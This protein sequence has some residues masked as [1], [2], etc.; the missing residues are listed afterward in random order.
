MSSYVE[1]RRIAQLHMDN[2][3]IENADPGSINAMVS[4]AR[5]VVSK[6]KELL[7]S[8]AMINEMNPKYTDDCNQEI[9]LWTRY[10]E[11]GSP[12]IEHWWNQ[13]PG[14]VESRQ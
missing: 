14:R 2:W 11:W 5:I 3:T 12:I 9:A 1:S 7:K 4:F 10:I 6:E 8:L 13:S